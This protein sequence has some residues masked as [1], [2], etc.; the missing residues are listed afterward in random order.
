MHFGWW[1]LALPSQAPAAR[2]A[3]AFGASVDVNVVFRDSQIGPEKAF[4]SDLASPWNPCLSR[5]A[6]SS[7]PGPSPDRAKQEGGFRL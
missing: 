1:L 2:S 4:C 3:G 6:D 5:V 7:M